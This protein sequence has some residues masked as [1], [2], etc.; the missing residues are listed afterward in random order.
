MQI[1]NTPNFE[2]IANNLKNPNVIMKAGWLGRYL[3]NTETNAV[4]LSSKEIRNLLKDIEKG[5][6]TELKPHACTILTKL[7]SEYSKCKSIFS[8]FKSICLGSHHKVS[9]LL[10]K[11]M[12][13]VRLTG[14]DAKKKYEN[15]TK[16]NTGNSSQFRLK[17]GSTIGIRDQFIKDAMR[18]GLSSQLLRKEDKDPTEESKKGAYENFV[19]DLYVRLEKN[20]DRLNEVLQF[21]EQGFIID[22]RNAVQEQVSALATKEEEQ[23]IPIGLKQEL[24]ISIEGDKVHLSWKVDFD[25]TFNTSAKRVDPTRTLDHGITA[26]L[27]VTLGPKNE[28]WSWDVV[29]ENLEP[30][31]IEV[32]KRPVEDKDFWSNNPSL[33]FKYPLINNESK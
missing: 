2:G 33:S 1:E 14:L 23:L 9:E 31:D 19:N 5:K 15:S 28:D 29:I 20:Q 32:L 22:L 24:Q 10:L 11:P 6:N 16:E 3:V 26:T 25:R 17:D 18:S 4:V 13:I 7:N 21:M 12:P 8:I 27:K 30:K